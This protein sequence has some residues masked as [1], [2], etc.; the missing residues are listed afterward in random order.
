[1]DYNEFTRRVNHNTR[2]LTDALANKTPLTNILSN[3]ATYTSLPGQLHS[4]VIMRNAHDI[5]PSAYLGL[6]ANL[7]SNG[8]DAFKVCKNK[9]IIPYELKTSEIN[10]DLIWK[11]VRG[12]LYIGKANIEH[13]NACVKSKLNASYNLKSLANT[14]SKRMKTILL[15]SDV[16]S[17]MT[18][19]YF[20]AYQL[21][22][23]VVMEKYL[24]KQRNNSKSGNITIK[25][26]SFMMNGQVAKTVVPLLGFNDWE[27]NVRKKARILAP[28]EYF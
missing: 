28:G 21:L 12:T 2:V 7:D 6:L 17:A 1:M 23:D 5:L 22:P 20:A 11:T 18:D 24:L 9:R 8:T 26:G 3:L 14:H 16:N 25:L 15:V 10:S 19:G 27:E 13:Q 4:S